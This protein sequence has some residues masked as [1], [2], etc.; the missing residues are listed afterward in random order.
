[1]NQRQKSLLLIYLPV[2]VLILIS[3][4]LYPG[5]SLVSILKYAVTLSLF[6]Y[7]RFTPKRHAVQKTMALSLMFV[8]VGDIFLVLSQPIPA[9]RSVVFLGA[10]CFSFGYLFLIAA[11]RKNAVFNKTDAVSAIL[12]FSVF[13]SAF[14]VIKPHLSGLFLPAAALFGLVLFSV[15]WAAFGTLHQGFYTRRAAVLICV[16]AVLMAVCDSAVGIS[17][18]HPR[19][20]GAFNPL[21]KTITWA[22]YVPGWT[23]LCV[24][25]SEDRL[26]T[27]HSG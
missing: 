22:S 19:F 15:V 20:S 14:F 9:L 6:L 17:F 21:L 23:L 11:Y 7:A 25:I 2:T 18:F 12:V 3:D 24:V 1:M 4:C 5:R 10:A 26:L 27:K 16:S 8:A 13:L